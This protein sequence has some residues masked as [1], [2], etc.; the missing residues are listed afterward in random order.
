MRTCMPTSVH[1]AQVSAALAPTAESVALFATAARCQRTLGLF[2][3]R[4]AQRGF[5]V[6]ELS[7]ALE[8]ASRG[9]LAGGVATDAC[10]EMRVGET[11]TEAAGSTR[12][13]VRYFAARWRSADDAREARAR[14]TAHGVGLA[15]QPPAMR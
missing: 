4:L 14:F 6:V 13:G 12:D 2:L 5:V 15:P 3:K 10:A 1:H 7:E 8:P 11:A 9:A